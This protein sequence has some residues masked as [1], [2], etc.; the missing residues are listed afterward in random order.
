M[1]KRILL[2]IVFCVF[3]NLLSAQKFSLQSRTPLDSILI[4]SLKINNPSLNNIKFFNFTY[5]SNGNSVNGYLLTP[6]APG[7][8]PCVIYNVGG[9]VG[10]Q[11]FSHAMALRYVSFLAEAG[12]VVIASNYEDQNNPD[13]VDEFGG[14]DLDHITD[15]VQNLSVFPEADTSRI[16][17]F[18]W[19][20][21]GMESY[22]LLKRFSNIKAMAVGGALTDM[23]DMFSARAG[24]DSVVASRVPGFKEN[25]K[26][27]SE[28]RSA[29][30]WVDKLP[31]TT[32]ILILHGNADWRVGP[33]QPLEMAKQLNKL[34]IPYRLVMFEG[35]DHSVSEH[36]PDMRVQVLSWFRRFLIKGEKLPN[37]KPHGN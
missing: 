26:N 34:Q 33:D 17:I 18:G 37:M 28:K 8:Y 5:K 12:Y 6:S 22:M 19:S 2:F 16:G 14:K 7:K 24:M 31:K 11:H 27:E 25:R 32:P 1:I 9:N 4:D 20:R 3:T 30:K 29:I 35:G 13:V 21:G 23:E 15:L 10:I 36:L